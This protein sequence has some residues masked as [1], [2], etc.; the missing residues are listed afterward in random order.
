M[1]YGRETA[2]RDVQRSLVMKPSK[3]KR[4]AKLPKPVLRDT[5]AATGSWASYARKA[6]SFRDKK[7]K[8]KGGSNVRRYVEEM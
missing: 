1:C 8:I 6:A 3:L 4:P 5:V 2:R 7:P